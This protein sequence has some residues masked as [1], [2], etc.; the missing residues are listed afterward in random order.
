[1]PGVSPWKEDTAEAG[2]GDVGAASGGPACH[3][4]LAQAES[5]WGAAGTTLSHQPCF[6]RQPGP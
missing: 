5:A 2:T 6:P 1:M 3:P 4:Y